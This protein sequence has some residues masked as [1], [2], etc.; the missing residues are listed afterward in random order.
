MRIHRYLHFSVSLDSVQSQVPS[1]ANASYNS[2]SE[3]IKVLFPLI[4]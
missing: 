1:Q 4:N 3:H 2:Q